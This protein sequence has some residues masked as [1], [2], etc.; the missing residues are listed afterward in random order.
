MK[1]SPAL[2]ATNVKSGKVELQFNENVKLSGAFEKVIVSPPQVQMPEIKAAGKYV[3]V[4]LF[5]TL[6]PN[7][8]YSIDFGDAIV[9][10]NEGNPYENFAYVFS[11]G[12]AVDTLAVSGTVLEAKDLKMKYLDGSKFNVTLLNGEGKIYPGQNVTFNV[13]GV[14]YNRTTDVNGVAH[15]NINLMPG[16]YIITS[17]YNGSNIAKRI[18][19]SS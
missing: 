15:L 7:T 18:T 11:T 14:F 9:D 5:D 16:E 6:Q 13:N 4:E 2:Y 8:T 17:S 10:N 3:S 12:D 1:A 19:I